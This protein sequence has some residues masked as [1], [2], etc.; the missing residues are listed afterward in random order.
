MRGRPSLRHLRRGRRLPVHSAHVGQELDVHYRWH[1]WF[2]CKVRIRQVQ[3][4]ADGRYVRVQIPSG[5]VVV[6]ASW[7]FDPLACAA[8]TLG[9]PR[10]DWAAL[11]EL[12]R[13][14]ID[15]HLNKVSPAE[16]AIA[17]EV[18][19]EDSQSFGSAYGLPPIE[20]AVR[21]RAVVETER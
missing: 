16:A 2:G 3:E 20:T 11:L 15:V 7:M 19:N 4:W 13:L 9:P 12:K 5:A 17:Q 10:V 14:L 6:M 21:H 8:M 1:P 18:Q